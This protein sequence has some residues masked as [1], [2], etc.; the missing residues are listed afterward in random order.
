LDSLARKGWLDHILRAAFGLAEAGF[1]T[2]CVSKL[3]PTRSHTVAAQGGIVILHKLDTVNLLSIRIVVLSYN[4]R[5]L[6]G[7]VAIGQDCL[8]LQ[9]VPHKKSHCRCSGWY[10]RCPW[11]VGFHQDGTGRSLAGH[12]VNGILVTKP[13]RTL[14]GIV[15]VPSPVILVLSVWPRLDSRLLVSPSCSPQEVTLS[16]LRVVS[17]LHVVNGILVTKPIRTLHGIVHVPSPVIL[18]HAKIQL[19]AGLRAAF[20]LA[21]AGFKTACVSKLFPTRSHTVAAQGTS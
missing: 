18:V 4:D 21:E 14:H 17:T 10:Q 13:I 16:L 2:A 19:G 3:F 7:Q 1:K 12:V 6:V 5:V 8:C 20:G 9:A 15:H 11:K